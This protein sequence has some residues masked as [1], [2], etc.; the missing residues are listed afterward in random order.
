MNI[1]RETIKKRNNICVLEYYRDIK[2]QRVRKRYLEY[3]QSEGRWENMLDMELVLHFTVPRNVN[4][5][6]Y[7]CVEIIK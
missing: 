4:Y 2:K 6:V 5:M 7:T 1:E 3:E